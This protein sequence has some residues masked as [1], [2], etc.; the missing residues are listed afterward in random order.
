LLL[1]W[2]VVQLFQTPP[3]A[4]EQHLSDILRL[5]PAGRI[6]SVRVFVGALS[7]AGRFG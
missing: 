4:V 2:P 5:Y 7:I 3:Q 6:E 1:G